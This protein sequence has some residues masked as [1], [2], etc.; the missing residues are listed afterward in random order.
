[1]LKYE[2]LKF[3]V[4]ALGFRVWGLGFLIMV[5]LQKSPKP[6]SNFK[7]PRLPASA[8]VEGV[9]ATVKKVIKGT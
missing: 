5:I 1:M 2:V 6:Y 9:L 8:G 7:A 4:L 3:A